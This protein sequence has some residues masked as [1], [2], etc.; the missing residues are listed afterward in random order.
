M[1]S[2]RV[3][4]LALLII[5]QSIRANENKIEIRNQLSHESIYSGNSINRAL[6]KLNLLGGK[7]I[8]DLPEGFGL[9][10]A[11]M[12]AVK[13]PSSNRPTLVYTNENGTINFVFNHTKNAIPK[14][15][16]PELLPAFVGQFS[17]IYPQIK[18][19]KNEMQKVNGKD[20]IVLEF[21]TPATDSKIY[22]IMYITVLEG[23]MLMCT[24][25]CLESQK[26]EWETKAKASLNSVTINE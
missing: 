20:F 12:L 1:E 3:L 18:W 7:L 19:Y 16:L 17:S 23:R 25:N 8:I 9:M 6:G 24:F 21:M 13:Y 11:E 14:D 2:I 15:K 22:N 4:V 26:S 10:S 5:G